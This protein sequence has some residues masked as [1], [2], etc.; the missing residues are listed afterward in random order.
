[1][2]NSDA[3]FTPTEMLAEDWPC[4]GERKDRTSAVCSLLVIRKWLTVDHCNGQQYKG[5][6]LKVNVSL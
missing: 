3:Y 4:G 2:L 6:K 5:S 1:M